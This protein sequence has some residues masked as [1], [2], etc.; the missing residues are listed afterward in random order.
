M[1]IRTGRREI[2]MRHIV[3]AITGLALTVVLLTAPQTA[4]E[5]GEEASLPQSSAFD[6]TLSEWMQLYWTWYFEG[7][8]DHV[9]WVKFLPLPA[10]GVH[11]SGSF[12]GDDPGV[13]QGHLHVTLEPDTSFVLPVSTWIGETYDPALGDPDDPPIPAK[14][15]TDPSKAII[16]VNIKS[17]DGKVAEVVMDSTQASVSPFYYGP[18]TL[19]VEY[20][21][22]TSYGAIGAIFAQGIA[23]VHL[24]LSVGVH[25]IDLES[26]LLLPPDAMYLNLRVYRDGVWVRYINSWTITVPPKK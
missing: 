19:D 9:G 6:K 4:V 5:A 25:T 3:T 2:A 22:P 23:F 15:F 1:N 11:V 10:K 17:I 12:T 21:E 20:E 16:K 26:E 13:L 7:G 14:F 24:P 18:V 8:S